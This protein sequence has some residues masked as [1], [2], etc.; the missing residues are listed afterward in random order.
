MHFGFEFGDRLTWYKPA[1]DVEFAKHSPGEVL[2]KYLLEYALERKVG[3]LDFTIGEEAFK[4]RFANHVRAN[5]AVRAFRRSGAYHLNRLLLD[6]R[7][8]VERFPAA[9][10][11]ARRMLGRWRTGPWL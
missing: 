7:A 10:R 5:Y 4:Y 6:A 9:A 2:I 11:I 1:F 8:A 3:E